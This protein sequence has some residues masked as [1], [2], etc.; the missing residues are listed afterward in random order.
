MSG[1]RVL[2]AMSGGVDSATA[3]ARAVDAGHEVTGVHLALSAQPVVLP[4][5]GAGL[6]H[7]GGR[8]GRAA[9][10]RRHRD[11]VLRLGHG[12]AIPSRRGAGFRRRVRRGPHPQPVPALQ[13][14]DQVR[15][16][17]RPGAGARLRRGMHRPLRADPRRRPAP[18]RGSRQGPVL[19]AGRTHLRADRPRHVPARRHAQGAGPR[20][21]RRGAGSPSRTSRT[22]TTSASSPT[23]TP[24]AS[25]PGS[26]ARRPARSSTS[27]AP[28]SASTTAPTPSPSASAGACGSAP[29]PMTASPA[30]S[31]TSSR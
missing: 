6:L 21:G 19:R 18:G 11:S 10:R 28:S 31:S 30:T 20:R 29:P 23:A 22:A 5:R 14:E 15:G 9:G 2:A 24:R 13:R 16:G 12:R 7:A 27:P 17:A 4:D 1:L 8:P 25:W 3:A 26:W